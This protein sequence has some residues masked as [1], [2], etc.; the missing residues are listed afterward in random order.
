VKDKSMRTDKSDSGVFV[1]PD[2]AM[3]IVPMR[4]VVLFP[5][6]ILPLTIGREQS[7]LAAQQAVKTE[8][9]VGILLQ[10]DAEIEVPTPDDLC[11]VGT[12][13]NIL[14]YVTLP[15]NTHVIVCQGLQRF[16]IAEHL[17]GYPFPVARVGRIEEPEVT[18]SQIEARMIQLRERAL[19]V[20]Q[21]LPQVS[22]E[23]L[24]AVKSIGQPAALAD[25]VASVTELKLSDRQ[26]VL[27]TVDLTQRLD[28]VLDCLLG[29]LEVL[30][31]SR[32][33]DERT[34]ASMDQRQREYLLREQLKSIQK[35]L[36]EG[37]PATALRWRRC[38]RPSPTPR[39]P[40][41]WRRRPTKS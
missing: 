37:K 9:P 13:A 24:G 34:K 38:A 32:E 6:M 19:E 3:I 35:E 36:G 8:R 4:N 41:R 2:D 22:Q 7:I 21:Y 29:R 10:R 5:G 15:D 14:R 26:R 20:L 25:L 33:L 23:L 12:V 39:C 18:D 27:E 1:I 16:R 40:R 17:P 28:V 31:L 11:L 30:R